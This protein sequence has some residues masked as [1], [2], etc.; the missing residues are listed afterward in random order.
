MSEKTTEK[1]PA[2]PTY[3]PYENPMAPKDEGGATPAE[4]AKETPPA[5]EPA[6]EEPKK[7]V[8]RR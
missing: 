4:P 3:T 8:S 2:E 5:K 1:P 7:E 6:R